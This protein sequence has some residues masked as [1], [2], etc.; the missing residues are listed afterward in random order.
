MKD[1]SK[2]LEKMVATDHSKPARIR[3]HPT[4]EFLVSFYIYT[5]LIFSICIFFS[6]FLRYT[7]L[8]FKAAK[9][10]KTELPLQDYATK[11][12]LEMHH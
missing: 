6:F 3:K 4:K 11:P 2:L 9:R 12:S 8:N 5:V 10:V 1:G 7:F